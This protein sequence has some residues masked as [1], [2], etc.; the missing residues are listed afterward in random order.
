M[1]ANCTQCNKKM[2]WTEWPT[3]CDDCLEHILFDDYD[4]DDEP[5]GVDANFDT[6]DTEDDEDNNGIL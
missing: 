5:S 2:D 6:F 4:E 1:P 3:I